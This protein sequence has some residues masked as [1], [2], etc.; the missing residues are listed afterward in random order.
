MGKHTSNQQKPSR[1][2]LRRET[3]RRL[4]DRALTQ[5]E[6][7]AVAG[8]YGIRTERCAPSCTGC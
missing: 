4:Q 1:L 7:R 6:L 2:S 8:G 3:L 5:D